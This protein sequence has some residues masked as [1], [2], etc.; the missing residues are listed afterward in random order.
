MRLQVGLLSLGAPFP[1]LQL[2]SRRYQGMT[3]A[4]WIYGNFDGNPAQAAGDFR[5]FKGFAGIVR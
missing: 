4:C 5:A 1:L 2:G 3:K